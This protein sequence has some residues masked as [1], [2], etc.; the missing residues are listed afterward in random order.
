MDYRD[1]MKPCP[2]CGRKVENVSIDMDGSGILRIDVDC[3]CGASIHIEADD[4]ISDWEGNRF[5]FGKNAFEKWNERADG[6]NK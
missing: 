4:V 6:D 5:Q 1:L 2:F 3:S